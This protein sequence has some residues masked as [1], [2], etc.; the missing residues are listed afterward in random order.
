M[1]VLAGQER[2]PRTRSPEA[3][4]GLLTA[5][6]LIWGLGR[7]P[8][9]GLTLAAAGSLWLYHGL[10]SPRRAPIPT[11]PDWQPAFPGPDEE[12]TRFAVAPS[13]VL[14]QSFGVPDLPLTAEEHGEA[15]V[16]AYYHALNRG[17]GQLP[18]FD[19]EQAIGDFCRAAG[20]VI[21]LRHSCNNDL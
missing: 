17:G 1:P 7:R 5:G 2:E 15:R 12:E 21:E 18:V 14:E 8:W 3:A 10:T 13:A 9:F 19:A 4:V 16:R 11:N 20:E 6:L